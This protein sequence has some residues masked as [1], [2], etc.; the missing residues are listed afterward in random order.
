MKVI[1]R[2]SVWGLLLVL[3]VVGGLGIYWGYNKYMQTFYIGF[4]DGNKVRYLDVPPFSDRITGAKLEILGECDIRFA[5]IDEQVLQFFQATATRYGYFFSRADGNNNSSFE[6][7]IRS[8]YVIKG[9]FE[10]NTLKL[11]WNP[12]LPPNLQKKARAMK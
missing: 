6:I 1:K 7:S 9:I 10:N 11:R 3:F 5:T 2:G 12:I 8:D 4:Y